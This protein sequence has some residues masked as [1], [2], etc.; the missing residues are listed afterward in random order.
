MVDHPDIAKVSFTGGTA[1]GRG[2][3]RAAAEKLMPVSL[4][5]G[6]KSPVLV[7]DDCDEDIALVTLLDSS[8][9]EIP[10]TD[11]ESG[12]ILGTLSY[13]DVL[14]AYHREVARLAQEADEEET[15]T[16][17]ENEE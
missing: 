6:G 4:E 16:L 10:V 14:R 8:Y 2:I 13:S 3:A 7:F 5:L 1:T 15:I 11:D 12:R 9:D 17:D